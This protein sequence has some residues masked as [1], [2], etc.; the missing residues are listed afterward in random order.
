MC[1][2][3]ATDV[4]QVVTGVGVTFDLMAWCN[5]MR[6]PWARQLAVLQADNKIEG[7]FD[8]EDMR[9]L[10]AIASQIS[11]SILLHS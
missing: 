7:V 4:A 6:C 9:V 5:T 11:V 3:C 1:R 10:R 2:E 8:D